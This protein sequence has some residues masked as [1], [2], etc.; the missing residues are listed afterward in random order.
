MKT[1]NGWMDEWM[2]HW[3]EGWMEGVDGVSE[4]LFY[5]LNRIGQNGQGAGRKYLKLK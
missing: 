1:I 3:M 2:D 5:V 4:F